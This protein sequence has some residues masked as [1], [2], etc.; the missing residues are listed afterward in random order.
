MP[1]DARLGAVAAAFDVRPSAGVGQ[2]E[3]HDSG[4]STVSGTI[5]LV[6]PDGARMRRI[7]LDQPPT[8]EPLT[9]PVSEAVA[10][11]RPVEMGLVDSQAPGSTEPGS[12]VPSDDALAATVNAAPDQLHYARPRRP[13]GRY[14]PFRLSG[15]VTGVLG[16]ERAAGS[17]AFDEQDRLLG[18]LVGEQIEDAMAGQLRP[19]ELDEPG[20]VQADGVLVRESLLLRLGE[21]AGDVFFRHRFG[22]GTDYVSPTVE[23]VLGWTPDD[24]RSDSGLAR[25]CIHPDDRHVLL[26]AVADPSKPSPAITVRTIGR[27]GSLSWHLLRLV[28]IVD[29]EGR[30]TGVEGMSTDVTDLE[31]RAA[32]LAHQARSDPLTKLAN[33][34]TFNQFAARS[35]SRLGRHGGLV[36]VLFLDLDGFKAVNDS[37]GHAAGD[38]VLIDVAKTLQHVVR[39]EDVVARLGGD[40]FAVLLGELRDA[41]EATATAQRILDALEAPIRIDANVAQ[42]S[43]GIGIAVTGTASVTPEQLLQRADTALYQAKRMGRGRWQVF[44]GMGSTLAGGQHSDADPATIGDFVTEGSVR[45]A[46]VGGDFRVHYLPEVDASSG[47]VTAVEA[48]LRWEHQE[49]GLLPAAEFIDRA[50]ELDVIHPVGDWVLHEACTQVAGWRQR[51]GLQMR[52]RINASRPQLHREGFAES[53]LRIIGASGLAADEVGL[54][55]TESTLEDLSGETGENL[56][57]LQEAG[58]RLTVDDFGTGAA[59]LRALRTFPLEQIKLDRTLVER[60]DRAG[61]DSSAEIVG[62]AV[63]LASVLGARILAEGVERVTQLERLREL[64]CGFFQG[65]LATEAQS[66]DALTG[67]LVAGTL[68]YSDVLNAAGW[69]PAP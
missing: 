6:S 17:P 50:N 61:A 33:R 64:H 34:L 1:I 30:V 23:S 20:L 36:G 59:T 53:M 32:A 56:R 46:L 47:A 67:L 11:G 22:V 2:A 10:R 16:V 45:A 21:V 57:R 25:R 35:L 68:S 24:F 63:E 49:L 51:F 29:N 18:D 5:W 41:A 19:D 65:F 55:I 13:F 39:K 8:W 26:E 40:E 37:L 4:T 44:G 9:G 43:T 69:N 66:A 31:L 60:I 14:V 58:V 42:I 15:R 48:L 28:P 12:H 52:L 3:G 27:D 62:L 7:N 54:D 38:R